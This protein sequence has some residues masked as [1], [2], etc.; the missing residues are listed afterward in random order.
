[1]RNPAKSVEFELIRAICTVFHETD[2]LVRLALSKL[3]GFLDSND[4]N[5]K[6]YLVKY[7]GLTALEQLI[8][9]SP[10]LA[11]EYRIFILEALQSKD[12]TIRLRA[13]RI[14]K[15]TATSETLP[16]ITSNL[17]SELEKPS[18]AGIKEEIISCLLYLLSLNQYELI[19]DFRW[20]FEVLLKLVQ[21]KTSNHEAQLSSIVL[22]VVL[23]VPELREEAVELSLQ[24]LEKFDSLR[25]ERCE[26]LTGLLFILGEFCSLLTQENF[27]LAV[28]LLLK[29]RWDSVGFH[30]NV[31][32]ALSSCLFKL[33]LRADPAEAEK[34]FAKVKAN[35]LAS[36]HMEA[37]ERSWFFFNVLEKC[38]K[39]QVSKVLMPFLPIH[40]AAQALIF[41]PDELLMPFEVDE[42]EIMTVR[43]DGSVEFHYFREEDFKDDQM[44]DVDR[45]LAKLKM[46]EKQMNDPFY[47]KPKKGKKKKGKKSKAKEE[48][49][50]EKEEKVESSVEVKPKAVKKYTVNRADPLVPQ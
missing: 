21:Q 13:L 14:V 41:P 16:E 25:S 49:I 8:A 30:E 11:E 42:K 33:A 44:T 1:M 4:P 22:D 46:K 2:E 28:S 7:L 20:M 19:I 3:N 23:R 47:I 32:N 35:C 12:L 40:P 50:I 5:C 18:N 39:D 27:R 34:C 45:K 37:Q 17:L 9:F 10:R 31:Y 29:P 48:Q 38:E 24:L 36:E 6:N 43:D 26:A 15:L